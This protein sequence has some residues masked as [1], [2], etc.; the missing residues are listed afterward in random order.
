MEE[1]NWLAAAE[2]ADSLGVDIINSSLGYTTFNDSL[3]NH[4]YSDMDGNTTIETKEQ[5]Y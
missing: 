3:E 2:Y 5:K 1:F 4:N